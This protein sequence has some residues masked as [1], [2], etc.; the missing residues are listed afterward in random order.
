LGEARRNVTP[1]RKP[2]ESACFRRDAA[3]RKAL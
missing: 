2:P 3:T 1:P